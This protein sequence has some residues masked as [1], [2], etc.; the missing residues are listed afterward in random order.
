MRNSRMVLVVGLA[1]LLEMGG[2]LYAQAKQ[3]IAP[4]ESVIPGLPFSPGVRSGDLLYLAG[5]MAT[6]GSGKL[7]PGSVEEQTRRT[8]ENLG[9]VL[10]A[11]GMSYQHVVAATVYLSDSRYF[12]G[13]N[14]V[15]REFFPQ[16]PPVR[17][18]VEADLVLP[19]GVVEISL[20]AADPRLPREYIDPPG[21]AENPLPYSRAIRVGDYLFLAGLVSQDPATG[22]PVGDTVAEQT[23]RTLENA[24]T[25][26]EAAGFQMSDL[27][28][29]RV[30]LEDSRDFQ[31][32]NQAYRTFFP[33]LP[34]TRATVRARLMNPR[35]KVEIML[36]GVRGE[37]RLIGTPGATPFSPALRVG[38]LLFVSGI[39]RSGPEL[40]GDLQGQTRAV[41]EQIR[42]LLREGGMDLEDVVDA[43][44][45]ISD[46]RH[47][48]AMNEVYR[49]FIPEAPPARATIGSRLM[50]PE[51][52]IEIAM[53]ARKD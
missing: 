43:T 34:P 32:M 48:S 33:E 22:Q 41:L 51:A 46:V 23:R 17:A 44:V 38:N 14:R 7:I 49:E 29:S 18:T 52:L 16:K 12:E 37:R 31:A 4:P 26:V 10:K 45:W 2:L 21:W 47:F 3:I 13:M 5:T 42:S 8:L 35:Y 9:T 20:I 53:T 30:W 27:T 39:V 40:R 25:L 19:G 24:R 36:S 50:S 28:V 11:A 15:Y 1:C 6:D